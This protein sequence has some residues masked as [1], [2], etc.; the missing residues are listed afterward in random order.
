MHGHTTAACTNRRPRE[1]SETPRQ[2]ID[3]CVVMANE[4][5]RLGID[6][7]AG[8]N[9]ENGKGEEPELGL[10]VSQ[11]SF[12]TNRFSLLRDPNI[13]IGDTGATADV[14]HDKTGC[15]N[16]QENHA[17]P[18]GIEGQ[19]SKC[20]Y[21]VDLPGIICDN[22]GNEMQHATLTKMRY[23]LTANFIC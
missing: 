8:L 14:T 4:L 23:N 16:E 19:A 15:I 5:R 9:E 17:L 21:Q 1:A 20:A 11:Q 2:N 7:P 13:F 10:L 22:H 3:Y 12:L 18:V 6:T